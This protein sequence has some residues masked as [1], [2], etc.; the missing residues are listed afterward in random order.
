MD[1]FSWW[2][3]TTSWE[4]DAFPQRSFCGCWQICVCLLLQ[5]D[6]NIIY[7]NRAALINPYNHGAVQQTTSISLLTWLHKWVFLLPLPI[8]KL[9][10][11]VLS[12]YAQ[13]EGNISKKKNILLQKLC[14]LYTHTVP[15]NAISNTL[16]S[17]H[18]LK[19]LYCMTQPI[20]PLTREPG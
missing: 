11:S 9:F 12:S 19:Y 13:K 8:P 2:E 16:L 5:E 1:L 7:W 4:E 6:G 15:Q 3:A 10:F 20:S 17:Q 14:P 18:R